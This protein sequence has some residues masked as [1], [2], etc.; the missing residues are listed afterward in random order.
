MLVATFGPT[1]GWS[2]K[3]I[4]YEA[5]VFTLEGHGTIT[6]ADVLSYDQKGQLVWAYEGLREWVQEAAGRQ[7]QAVASQPTPAFER[8]ATSPV[9]KK[10]RGLKIALAIVGV[11]VL[12]AIVGAAIG[13][14]DDETAPVSDAAPLVTIEPEVAGP[15]EEPATSTPEPAPE[16]V[17]DTPVTY[18]GSGNRVVKITKPSGDK[19]EPVVVSLS[20]NGQANFAVWTLDKKL[21]QQ[22]LLV[23]T[24]GDYKGTVPVDFME[25]QQTPRIQV[26][27]D[28][29]WKMMIEPL[30]S[31]RRFGSAVKG[32]GDDVL[33][34]TA[35]PKVAN[36]KH[37]SSGNFAVWYYGADG[38]ELLVNEIG[39]YKGQSPFSGEAYIVITADGK[40][41][42]VAR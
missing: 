11:I 8:P 23:N 16:P 29:S 25:G 41:S 38:N 31:V 20:H 6:A 39:N 9:P 12:L 10:R 13:G 24:I 18:R 34:Y 28:G 17:A 37:T 35:G 42:I 2:G 26:E 7:S 19:D 3:T 14:S 21:K 30:S 15:T 5:D 33:Y 40:W 32:T 4:T 27:A 1:T 22:E 36:I